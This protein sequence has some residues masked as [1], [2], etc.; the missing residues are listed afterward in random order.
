MNEYEPLESS[1]SME[2]LDFE[3][4]SPEQNKGYDSKQGF[5]VK[6]SPFTIEPVNIKWS[7]EES[8][9]EDLQANPRSKQVEADAKEVASP[10]IRT[11][12]KS[13]K[14]L[15]MQQPKKARL[16]VI[17]ESNNEEAGTLRDSHRVSRADYDLPPVSKFVSGTGDNQYPFSTKF[18][19]CIKEENRQF[20]DH[21]PDSPLSPGLEPT[22]PEEFH[23]TASINA[24]N[25]EAKATPV[26]RSVPR[27]IDTVG[28]F[29]NVP[30]GSGILKHYIRENSVK[31]FDDERKIPIIRVNTL[32]NTDF[33]E[34]NLVSDKSIIIGGSDLGKVLTNL[35]EKRR[36][37]LESLK[38]VDESI[39]TV[40][41]KMEENRGKGSGSQEFFTL[42]IRK[43]SA[44]MNQFE[45]IKLGDDNGTVGEV[46]TITMKE[47]FIDS[48]PVKTTS[49]A[50]KENVMISIS[51]ENVNPDDHLAK[52]VSD[53]LSVTVEIAK[54][55]AKVSKVP[56]ITSVTL[57]S[58][59]VQATQVS[60]ASQNTQTQKTHIIQN[61]QI[62][63]TPEKQPQKI[64][65][66]KAE[67]SISIETPRPKNQPVAVT[68]LRKGL[69]SKNEPLQSG[70]RGAGI[71]KRTLR[72]RDDRR[73][74]SDKK[75]EAGEGK[76]KILR[77]MLIGMDETKMG[78]HEDTKTYRISKSLSKSSRSSQIYQTFSNTTTHGISP[79]KLPLY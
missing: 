33:V 8:S 44:N 49:K 52:K 32:Q 2:Q 47:S 61:I 56:A 19:E 38:E 63:T 62:S 66:I 45:F 26:D 41:K 21:T 60:Q 30:I 36:L 40:K 4:P 53:E 23:R 67:R 22:F 71:A 13:T 65:K 51:Q 55:F 37:L 42:P 24:G 59:A 1:A 15:E 68:R 17:N 58:K 11:T 6:P 35:E 34:R 74:T 48:N 57:A 29:K 79:Y 78:K 3:I 39:S 20:Q 25:E 73:D 77:R 5:H 70:T 7:L 31:Y 76:R 16:S 72:T 28:S 14:I 50:I 10:A 69:D 43:D 27:R 12:F 18:L 46:Q 54:E 9:T 75:R 64:S